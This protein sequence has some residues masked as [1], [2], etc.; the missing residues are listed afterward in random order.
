MKNTFKD[1]ITPIP[2]SENVGGLQSMLICSRS[3]YWH[4]AFINLWNSNVS[5]IC[6]IL[7]D[8]PKV[9][10]W[11]AQVRRICVESVYLDRHTDGL[12][13]RHTSLFYRWGWYMSIFVS[14][15]VSVWDPFPGP[16]ICIF[17]QF[18]FAG[19]DSQ[20]AKVTNSRSQISISTHMCCTNAH[21]KILAKSALLD[22]V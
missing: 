11:Q 16:A 17:I 8:A 1:G 13:D 14:D 6:T 7:L 2:A 12:T 5:L 9:L 21:T 20:W 22:L 18:D 3:C 19:I 4:L 10:I 15:R